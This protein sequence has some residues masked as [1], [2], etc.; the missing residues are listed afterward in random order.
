MI[1]RDCASAQRHRLR[2]FLPQPSARPSGSGLL[3]QM[4]R[5]VVASVNHDAIAAALDGLAIS[6]FVSNFDPK[7]AV[8][9]GRDYTCTLLLHLPGLP[10]MTLGEIPYPTDAGEFVLAVRDSTSEVAPPAQ[11]YYVPIF[12][13]TQPQAARMAD[14]G[15]T[16]QSVL[17]KSNGVHSEGGNDR[18]D[19]ADLVCVFLSDLLEATI[20]RR[21]TQRCR[22]LARTLEAIQK[23]SSG[24][25]AD[26]IRTHLYGCL[27]GPARSLFNKW[28][29]LVAE[30][31]PL[32]RLCQLRELSFFGPGGIHPLSVGHLEL[33]DLHPNDRDCLC[34]VQTPQGHAVGLRL[35]L[36]R[37][38][39]ID[40]DSRTLEGPAERV[41]GD[42]LGLAAS[43]VPFIEH[44][45]AA[46][47][48]MGANMMRQ[49]MS[50]VKREQP[51]VQTGYEQVVAAL[52]E[53][54]ADYAD[55][56]TI[57]L[58]TNLRTAYTPWGLDGFEDGIVVSSSAAD[59]LEA[60]D[61]RT[62]W[63]DVTSNWGGDAGQTVVTRDNPH[64]PEGV[65]EGLDE[66]GCVRIGVS[67]APGDVLVS[68]VRVQAG[69]THK[70]KVL[71]RLLVNTIPT[72]ADETA[73]RS[74]RMPSGYA[75]SVAEVIDSDA[76]AAV[77]ALAPGVTRR[78]GVRVRRRI[79]LAIGDKVAGRHGNKGV[80][81]KILP[82]HQMPF[83]LSAAR[84][85]VALEC[86]S[87]PPHEHVQVILN[88]IG[89]FA[90][91]NVGQL[92]ETALSRVAH[93][94]GRPLVVQ[95][96]EDKWTPQR[97]RERLAA[98]GFSADGSEQL[99]IKTSHGSTALEQ[100]TFV[101]SQYM[102]R[103][104]H[105]APSKAHARGRGKPWEYSLRDDQ[106]VGGKRYNGGQRIGEMETWA[107]AGH[108]AWHLLDDCLTVRSDDHRLRDA[109][110]TSG[111]GW[112][113]R[114]RPRALVNLVLATR[115]M[116][117][118]L[119]VEG[120]DGRDVSNELLHRKDGAEIASVSIDLCS[121]GSVVWGTRGEVRSLRRYEA[122]K[123]GDVSMPDTAGLYSR[124]LFQSDADLASMT[125]GCAVLNPLAADAMRLI[126]H[127][128]PHVEAN[129]EGQTTAKM[130]RSRRKRQKL[131]DYIR[132]ALHISTANPEWPTAPPPDCD[133]FT[134]HRFRHA[135]QALRGGGERRPADYLLR[136]LAVLPPV[137]RKERR[138]GRTAGGD[139][140]HPLN[141]LYL[142]VLTANQRFA[143][144]SLPEAELHDAQQFLL[145]AVYRL[146]MG[147]RARGR[148]C[149]GL[150]DLMSGKTG[151][152]R[153]HLAG[154]RTD[155]SGRAVIVGD[156]SVPLDSVS[157]P[158]WFAAT[159]GGEHDMG[160]TPN[161]VVL[162]RQPSLHRMSMQA[163]HVQ[164]HT[165]SD[166]IRINPYVCRGFNAD[167]DGDTIAVHAPLSP[168]A[169]T[170]ATQLLP[171]MNGLSQANNSVALGF[172]GDLA[173][174]AALLTHD[175]EINTDDAIPPGASVNEMSQSDIRQRVLIEGVLTT[176]GRRLFRSVLPR[177]IIL[178][179]RG[180]SV[181]DS[182]ELLRSVVECGSY[183]TRQ[184]AEAFARLAS[185]A[186]RLS[187][188]SLSIE[189]LSVG[190][191]IPVEASEPLDILGYAKMSG[192]KG[193]LRDLRGPRE[194]MR[195]SGRKERTEPI[196]SGLLDGHTEAEYFLACHGARAGLVD[197]GLNTAP[198]GSLLRKLIYQA[199]RV[200]ITMDDCGNGSSSGETPR[201]RSPLHCE[202]T[203]THGAPGICQR[204]YGIDPATREPPVLGLPVG[205]LAAQA[206]GER[207]TQITLRTFQR[208]DSAGLDLETLA[209]TLTKAPRNKTDIKERLQWLTKQ[210]EH[211]TDAPKQ[212]HFEVL[213]RALQDKRFRPE[214]ITRIAFGSVRDNLL[215]AASRRETDS[216]S[217]VIS[218]I[219]TATFVGAASTL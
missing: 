66:S 128:E 44:D 56:A 100:R 15:I 212:V 63:V 55:G 76:S 33:R 13:R 153:G 121:D 35:F 62:F 57:A 9:G 92:Y 97:L 85:C 14:L 32:S 201:T 122:S 90:R 142:G 96:F 164:T 23:A 197:K 215:Y 132:V 119:R 26:L 147:G 36:A 149:A 108:S 40:V 41:T 173:L 113:A 81:V 190:T 123:A 218:K 169:R 166:A 180:L 165:D 163:F 79:P 91:L 185:D 22:K 17:R 106:P 211:V 192:L 99:Y 183:E 49:A 161:I 68:A 116:G 12:L 182:S 11:R 202:A 65:A 20:T 61:E 109:A 136:T 208:T 58:G 125:L 59:A 53:A 195:R 203:D 54:P 145:S 216:L 24:L 175:A 160:T 80:I 8:A 219:V 129:E 162:N 112:D 39:A 138:R 194:P 135:L 72:A 89:V 70:A 155:Y 174:A 3:P 110:L 88:P 214:F 118:D 29:Q 141:L 209:P 131:A 83:A 111:F 154:K 139:F 28:G 74:L 168:Q 48:L 69:T 120:P 148:E 1:F 30:D 51:L 207:T 184:F 37:A 86:K 144:S 115:A 101:G 84:D 102:L 42:S 50:L 205:I 60:C 21:I 127:N 159:V 104:W 25:T 5:D 75:G 103:L 213:L 193:S 126:F 176:M 189:A 31:Q 117:L 107:L 105:R 34:P 152:L 46:R 186:L 217:G 187:G 210:F 67:V 78:I 47:A 124:T 43:L 10:T 137:F 73:D 133:A 200:F 146:F 156:A 19:P 181:K 93:R 18:R 198:A 52:A 2:E 82:D 134:A 77:I 95:P 157:L 150:V 167:F 199:Q 172:T 151:L 114:R 64:L 38:A 7:A 87:L 130:S 188:L 178:R 158:R 140:Q 4:L 171:S 45:D 94:I 98:H 191:D 179:N 204:C 143:D 177:Q 196:E 27:T 71:D 6:G 170:E 16:C 206:V